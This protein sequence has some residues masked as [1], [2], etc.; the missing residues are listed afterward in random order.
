MIQLKPREAVDKSTQKEN[1][2]SESWFSGRIIMLAQQS[3]SWI[4]ILMS[5]EKRRN[6][7]PIDA[8]PDDSRGTEIKE[9]WKRQ[10]RTDSVSLTVFMVLLLVVGFL[11]VASVV[12]YWPQGWDNS[13][14]TGLILL[15]VS[16]TAL[17][18]K[19]GL[20]GQVLRVWRYLKK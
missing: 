6:K 16:S 1:Q 4:T 17:L 10:K 3:R 18:F 13:P 5:Y 15:G 20:K 2:T 11:A 9:L 19:R 8:F 12:L 7:S 14:I